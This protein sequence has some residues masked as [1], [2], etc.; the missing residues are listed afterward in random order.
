MHLSILVSLILTLSAYLPG[1][2]PQDPPPIR[3]PGTAE[4]DLAAAGTAARY[5][6]TTV[7]FE[8]FDALLL[9][10]YALAKVGREARR[11]LLEL[12]VIDAI[13][14]EQGLKATEEEIQAM[15]DG[16]EKD[17]VATRTAKSIEEWLER[18]GVSEAEFME[19]LRLAVLQQ[20]LARRALGIPED[21]PI[22]GEQLEMWSEEAIATRE[23]TEHPAPWADGV[24]VTGAGVRVT[25][26]EFLLFLRTR[27]GS[28]LTRDCLTEL[29]L[30]K[31]MRERMPDLSPKTLDEAVAAEIAGRAGEVT[32]D[33]KY[34]GLSYQQLLESQGI[35]WESWPTDPAIL[36]SALARLWVERK[37]DEESLRQLYEDQREKFDSEYGE[38]V[39]TWVILLN[40]RRVPDGIVTRTFQAAEKEL[41]E[42]SLKITSHTDFQA[43]ATRL[44][45]HQATRSQNG[46]LG[47][48]TRQAKAGP[49][50]AREA[51]FKALDS[52][53]YQPGAPENSK[54]RL[55]GPIRTSTGVLLLWLGKRRPKPSWTTMVRHVRAEV[56][57]DFAT[58]SLT[59][60]EVWT[61]LDR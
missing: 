41:Y 45:E 54:A 1:G 16:I 42:L 44:S 4:S 51:I 61:Y 48:V 11:H 28:E 18:E 9:G 34:Q 55:L 7:S 39:E 5:Q 32:K 6:G 25:R 17:V 27:L 60:R 59:A 49:S 3:P 33:P 23:L 57:Q 20:T 52:G 2:A 12:Q 43:R 10:R 22:S 29:L 21:Q 24:L 26:D 35:L 38:A 58:S 15:R 36:V 46:R 13:A 14:A 50:P 30:V 40:A 37:Y 31:R 8:E 19:K 53:A 56:R 47:W